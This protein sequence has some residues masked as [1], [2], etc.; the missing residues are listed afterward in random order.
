LIDQERQKIGDDLI[1]KQKKFDS[2]FLLKCTNSGAFGNR[3]AYGFG[4]K[5]EGR[6]VELGEHM[7]EKFGAEFALLSGDL[8]GVESQRVVVAGAA[9]LIA[10]QHVVSKQL[11]LLPIVSF[12]FPRF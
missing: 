8:L 6:V 11:H 1:I 9:L 12:R 7:L 3:G 4:G 10:L 2:N 5:G